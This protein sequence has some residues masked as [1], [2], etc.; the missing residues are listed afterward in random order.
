MK[1]RR[2]AGAEPPSEI[3]LG[4]IR[5]LDENTKIPSMEED[6]RK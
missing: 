2:L 3:V 6:Q 4:M 1:G 5:F